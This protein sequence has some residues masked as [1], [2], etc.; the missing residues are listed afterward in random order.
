MYLPGTGATYWGD[1]TIL[2]SICDGGV[3]SADVFVVIFSTHGKRKHWM[4]ATTTRQ[5]HT[6]TDRDTG[7]VRLE[8]M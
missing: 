8:V 2:H 6:T 7:L 1:P 5:L 3:A 4:A